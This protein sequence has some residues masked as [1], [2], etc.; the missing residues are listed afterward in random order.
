MKGAD[1]SNTE[2]KKME[3]K[4]VCQ[5]RTDTGKN[6]ASRLR[7]SGFIPG[8]MIAEGKA[9][10]LSVPQRDFNRLL[11]QGLR[12]SSLIELSIEGE[13]S[14]SRV[15][16]KEL[17][18]NPIN[19]APLHVDFYRVTPGRKVFVTVAVEYTGL[20]KGVKGG[21]ALEHFIRTLKVKATPESLQD[22]ITVDV[23]ELDV[24]ESVHLSDLGL[25][26]DWELRM[27]GNPIVLKVARSRMSRAGEG[28]GEGGAPQKSEAAAG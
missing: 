14:P 24:G 22:V 13:S 4:L 11:G 8:N 9:V 5:K 10:P 7:R 12:S 20:S 17:Q 15:F 27:T 26:S 18:R 21:G 25:P 16:V 1:Q 19:G 2:A 23:T 6:A 3:K 28:E